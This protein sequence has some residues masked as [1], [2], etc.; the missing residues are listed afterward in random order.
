MRQVLKVLIATVQESGSRGFSQA[1]ATVVHPSVELSL[2]TTLRPFR[3]EKERP[4]Q[5]DV[6]WVK[7]D[8]IVHID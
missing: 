3:F 6:V 4:L 2:S 5:I 8:L 1:A 7:T